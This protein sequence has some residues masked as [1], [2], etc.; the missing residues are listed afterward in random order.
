MTGAC[1][2]TLIGPLIKSE[3]KYC[4]GN[5]SK[6]TIYNK[7]N[8]PKKRIYI[9]PLDSFLNDSIFFFKIK[10][11]KININNEIKRANFDIAIIIIEKRSTR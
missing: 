8:A 1:V 7:S 9:M 6:P 11:K 5:I 10:S 3:Y 2:K 4:L